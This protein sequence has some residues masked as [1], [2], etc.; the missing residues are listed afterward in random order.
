[1]ASATFIVP[2]ANGAFSKKPIGPFQKIVLAA[3]NVSVKSFTVFGPM[4]NAEVPPGI[5]ATSTAVPAVTSGDGATMTSS[6]KRQFT[7]SSRALSRSVRA[8]GS[9]SFS[10]LE[11]CTS[12]P[13]AA[14]NVLAIAPPMHRVS[15]RANSAS[16][17]S[18]L[19][20][21]F[22]PPRTAT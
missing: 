8:S 22:A 19:S 7:F 1:M 17:T 14:R 16:T 4:S 5:D 11:A 2:L 10:I 13:R 21:T 6:G 3:T 12:T 20:E 9:L 15:T 18:I